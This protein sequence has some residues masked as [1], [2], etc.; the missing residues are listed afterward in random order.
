MRFVHLSDLHIGKSVKEFSMTEDIRYMF[1]KVFEII[2]RE[3]PDAVIIAGDVYDRTV[4]SAEAVKVLDDFIATLS[5]RRIKTFIISGNHDC[6]ERIAF[7]GRVMESAGIHMSPVYDGKV[8]PISVKDEYGEVNIYMLP[9]VK[10]AHVR[11]CFPEESIESYTDAIRVAISNMDIDTSKRN[12]LISHQ[13]VTGATRCESEG[14]SVGGLDNV[15]ASVF[16]DFDYV[17]L[18]HIHS[19]QSI[20]REEV[21]YCGTLLKYSFSEAEGFK[22]VTVV[23][24]KEKGDT[25]INAIPVKPLRDMVKIKGSFSQV[26]DR[27]FVDGIDA[28]NYVKIILTDEEEIMDGINKLRTIYKNIMELEYDNKRTRARSEIADAVNI[29]QKSHLELFEEFYEMQN[30]QKMSDK[31]IDYSK[32]LMEDIWE[33]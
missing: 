1:A 8:V 5:K 24:M 20:G 4:P 16:D 33:S 12:I 30:G 28:D 22:S 14:V 29:E 10:P 21:R 25:K 9:F 15:D 3:E 32:E 7:G 27:D 17:A 2:D 23:E 18:G 26:T 6:P 19:P 31:Q 11:R 13:F